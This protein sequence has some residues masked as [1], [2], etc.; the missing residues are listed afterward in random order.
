MQVGAR[1]R[2]LLGT[3]RGSS[4]AR[5]RVEFGRTEQRR[6]LR[7]SD[8]ERQLDRFGYT[9]L[10][11]LPQELLEA[12][13]DAY[14][15]LGPA[16]DDPKMALNWSFHSTARSYKEAVSSRMLQ[17]VDPVLSEVFDRYEAFLTTFII[18]WPGANS[19]FAPHQ[20][21]SLV[22]ERHFRGV[23]AWIPLADTGKRHGVDNGMLHIVPGSHRFSAELR[24]SDVDR[25]QF[26]ELEELVR[27][28]AV[29]VPMDA[30]EMLVFDN[31]V[32]HYSMPNESEEPRVVLSFG[33]RPQESSC[34]I[35]RP[36]GDDGSVA[37]YE[38]PD[39]FYLD[40]LPAEHESWRPEGEPLT[41]VN[42]QYSRPTPAEFRSMC[43]AVPPP[44]RGCAVDTAPN[45]W[46]DPGVFCAL[47]GGSTGL[48][49]GDRESRNNAQLV[50]SD[51]RSR[52]ETSRS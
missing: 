17:I 11:A 39:E 13:R 24:V 4:R 52:L 5:R 41:V 10:P 34:V 7:S 36:A 18:K 42:P 25:W 31:R 40:V 47:C 1:I 16:P 26:S 29:A 27:E 14:A 9:V 21:P 44:P 12:V 30:G 3:R 35:L 45:R 49:T 22:D 37:L 23:T 8:H 50:C 51:C 20:D 15:E 46:S 38:V 48:G 19:A 6:T 32:I 43:S 28:H 33:M 2:R